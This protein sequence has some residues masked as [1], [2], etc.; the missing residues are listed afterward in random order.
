MWYANSNFV[1]PNMSV[2]GAHAKGTETGSVVF[3]VDGR[4]VVTRGGDDT[5]KRMYFEVSLRYSD[6]F[7]VVWDLRSFKKPLAVQENVATLYPDTNAVFSPDEKYV[8]TGAGATAKGKHGRLLILERRGLEV[9]KELEMETT[10]VRVVW[11]PKINQAR[12]E[13]FQLFIST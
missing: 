6:A 1:R 9:V 7:Q 11:H 3:S 12:S 13:T 5:V 10:P 2:E 8:L 4:S